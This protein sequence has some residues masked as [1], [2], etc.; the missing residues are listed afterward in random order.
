M[1]RKFIAFGILILIITVGFSGCLEDNQTKEKSS[2]E[3][4]DIYVDDDGPADY[5][6]IA[7][8]IKAS[9]DGDSIF[10]Y[11]GI[12]YENI[13]IDKRI[14]LI[15]EDKVKT[16]IDGEN[17]LNV[18]WI[19]TSSVNIS[20]FTIQNGYYSGILISDNYARTISNCKIF[21]NIITN[22]SYGIT[23]S[24]TNY[25][26][27]HNNT[28]SNNKEIGLIIVNNIFYPRTPET[29]ITYSTNNVIYF[30]E[31]INNNISAYESNNT[32]TDPRLEPWSSSN[33]I[34][35]NTWYNEDL[36]L[37]NYWDDCK[38]S[39]NRTQNITGN[40]IN[41]DGVGDTPYNISGGDNQDRFPLIREGFVPGEI[42]VGFIGTLTDEEI[43]SIIKPYNL[44]FSEISRYSDPKFS[45]SVLVE[46]PINEEAYWIKIFQNEDN[47]DYAH[48][49]VI[50]TLDDPVNLEED[51]P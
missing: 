11:N 51:T 37:G 32:N 13:E 25:C 22:C 29:W 16:I 50:I 9:E 21:G 3:K 6:S 12:Y 41:G 31:F 40:D 36:E 26:L 15:G 23:L 27:I 24:G 2:T 43:S 39:W 42:I 17:K 48:L 38:K 30:N 1:K 5:I 46:V 18:I 47:V 4:Y 28:I 34:T 44:S 14:T 10:V 20:G 19:E 7:E 8:A 45:T 49:N 33:V 35:N